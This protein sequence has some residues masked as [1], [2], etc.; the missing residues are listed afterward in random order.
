MNNR[1]VY[2]NIRKNVEKI[3]GNNVVINVVYIRN[4]DR[5]L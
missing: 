2:R 5:K 4:M 1:K 3:Y